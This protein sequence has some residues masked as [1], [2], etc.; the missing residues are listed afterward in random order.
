MLHGTRASDGLHRSLYSVTFPNGKRYIGISFKPKERWAEHRRQ[1]RIGSSGPLYRAL[2][3]YGDGAVFKILVVG[4]D[5][6]IRD[7]EV[8]L[9]A[10][11][12]TD[13]HA[14]G[15]NISKG[16]DLGSTG[17]K[18]SAFTRAK[19]SNAATGRKQ[20]P[21]WVA[22]RAATQVGKKRSAESRM[23]MSE[24][25]KN[26]DRTPQELARMKEMAAKA[27]LVRKTPEYRE[28]ARQAALRRWAKAK[29]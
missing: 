19:M 2:R 10:A 23:R 16:G 7:L 4:A 26:R 29:A 20:S 8:A 17:V 9:I 21:E 22:A 1:A 18:A 27:A 25:Q 5:A 6:Y 28:T 12:K 14:A 13:R 11:W 15:Y 3:K 24:G